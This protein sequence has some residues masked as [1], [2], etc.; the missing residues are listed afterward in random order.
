MGDPISDK[1]DNS[2]YGRTKLAI[3]EEWKQTLD[4]NVQY[5]VLRPFE[6]EYG[7]VGPQINKLDDG[8]F[9]Y[10]PGGGTQIKLGYHDYENAVARPDNGNTDKAY[11]KVKENTKLSQNKIK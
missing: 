8:T 11:L 10:L 9:R 5:E 4:R 3:K 1:I 2:S 6:V 7:P